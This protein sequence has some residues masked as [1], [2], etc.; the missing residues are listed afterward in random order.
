MQLPLGACQMVFQLQ[1]ARKQDAVPPTRDYMLDAE[2]G[3][4]V[5]R[6]MAAG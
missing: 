6:S 5:R 2:K 1:F 3:I 4:T